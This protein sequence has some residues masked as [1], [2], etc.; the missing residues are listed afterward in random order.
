MS[1]GNK[2]KNKNNNN[3]NNQN[4]NDNKLDDE[5]AHHDHNESRDFIS[6]PDFEKLSLH[7]SA[8]HSSS[9]EDKVTSL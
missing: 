7:S 1:H 5:A 3:N 4:D 2:N 6:E 8:D 9:T